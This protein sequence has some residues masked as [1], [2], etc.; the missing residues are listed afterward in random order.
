MSLGII[1]VEKVKKITLILD[2]NKTQYDAVLMDFI[3]PNMAGPTGK[4]YLI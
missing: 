4:T 3:M 1:A 2:V